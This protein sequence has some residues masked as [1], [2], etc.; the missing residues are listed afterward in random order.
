MTFSFEQTPFDETF[1]PDGTPR[2]HWKT[3]WEKLQANG[4]K[5][6]FL[7]EQTTRLMHADFSDSSE[8]RAHGVVP[9]ILSRQDF[10]TISRGLVQ[11]AELFNA[12]LGDLYGEQTLI[13]AG[14][15][16]PAAVF[17]N[18][19]YFPALR[20]LKPANGVFVQE[21]TADLERAPDGTFWVVADHLQIPQGV[22]RA[23]KNRRVSTRILPEAFAA[24]QPAP[25]SDFLETF[26]RHLFS[27]APANKIP[28]V[29]LLTASSNRPLS[30]EES[31]FARNLGIVAVEPADL[32]V[33][34]DK[35][36]LKNID[37]LKQ[38]DVIL[39]RIADDLCDPLELKGSS[40]AGV[41]GLVHAV[42]AG[43]VAVLNPLGTG[44]AESPVFKAFIHGICRHLTGKELLL[45]SIAAWWG[46]QD[47]EAAY[48]IE[49]Q[50]SLQFFDAFTGAETAPSSADLHACP[51]RCVG[52][53][54]VNASAM[55]IV[56]NGNIESARVRL[57][58]PVVY[59]GGAYRVMAG[60][61]AFTMTADS[62]GVCDVWVK[63]PVSAASPSAPEKLVAPSRTAFELTSR[64]ADN[65]Y[66]LGRN[67]ERGEQLAR[68]LR[69]ALTRATQ[70]SDFP[71]P[72]DVATLLCVLALEG[73]MPFADFQDSA[74]REKALKTLKKIMCSESYGFG[75]CFLFKR[76]KEM[77]DQL[78]DR[79]SMDTWELFTA[80][81]P[82]LP[83]ESANYPVILNRLDSII[84]RQNAL[85]GLIHEDMTRDHGWRF[86]EIGRRLERGLQ[87]LN[88]L[89]GI[90]SCKI[91]GF[92]ASLESLLET[93]D[94]RMTYRARYMSV[95]SVPLVVDL[96]VCDKSNP[97]SLIFQVRELRRAI[98]ALERESRTPAL[99][100]T[101]NTLL[102]DM[103]KVLEDIDIFTVDL[104]A[105]TANLRDRLQ[106]FS[107]TLTLSCFV[108]NTS[109]RQ[110][111]AYNKGKLK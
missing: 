20:G 65:M 82:L 41:A 25:V 78:H 94:S 80:L 57:C 50:R 40:M 10:E 107:D 90:Q 13:S 86:L 87:I 39:R 101:E 15:L 76:L 19:M 53:E 60:G 35:V 23:V 51:E 69:V 98:V 103:A 105:L 96:L 61:L 59:D 74:E 11:R 38:V 64:I 12:M 91:A 43:T 22:G 14:V 48:L 52:Q 70:G 85:S 72:N 45:P 16:P 49:H 17:G 73:H 75:L 109:T 106:A 36:F 68:L 3:F 99:F 8:K 30:F 71:D 66:W 58:I 42:R 9:F 108:H 63:A 1:A 84:V 5:L 37:G 83:E 27:V 44:L 34:G 24:V 32:T 97:R 31:Y 77:A 88:L 18:P 28:T 47:K 81:A 55:P 100:A 102:R 56:R 93:S 104:P 62:I 95:P 26:R 79:L 54:R 6:A 89:S 33:R 21:Y 111:P 4:E 46:G 92:D 2:P 67:L 29:V 7:G 110:G